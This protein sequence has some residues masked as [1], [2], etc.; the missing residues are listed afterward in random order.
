MQDDRNLHVR[1]LALDLAD[2]V[3]DCCRAF[4]TDERFELTRQVRRAVISVPANISEGAARD[5]DAEFR[6]F[7]RIAMGS[8]AEVRTLLE[9][10]HRRRWLAEP[11]HAAL[12]ALI[13]ELRQALLNLLRAIALA[14]RRKQEAPGAKRT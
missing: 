9:F 3:Y 5:S 4:P 11:D 1:R 6:R 12:E 2:A 7:I 10:A 8:L 13:E 14:M